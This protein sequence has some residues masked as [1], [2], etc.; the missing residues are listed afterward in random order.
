MRVSFIVLLIVC[1]LLALYL[2]YY[3]CTLPERRKNN[4]NL[5][6]QILLNEEKYEAEKAKQIARV[7][8]EIVRNNIDRIAN[9][10]KK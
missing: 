9:L 1:V 7:T 4:E 6:R 2:I 8:G 3:L 5:R 10:N